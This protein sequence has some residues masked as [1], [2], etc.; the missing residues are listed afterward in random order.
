MSKIWEFFGT[1]EALVYV[2]DMDS[3]ELVYMNQKALQMYGFHS[4]DEIIGKKCYEVL[5]NCSAPCPMCNSRDLRQGYFKE[6]MY[7]NPVLERQVMLKATIVEVDGRKYRME[8]AFDDIKQNSIMSLEA[9][10]NKGVRVALQQETPSQTLEVLLEY[11]GKAL[12]GERTYIFERNEQGCDDNTYEWVA[13]GVT[14]EKDNLQNLPAEVCA[15]WYRNFRVGRHIVIEDLEDIRENDP[16]Q[17]E[18]LK[19]QN[20]HSLIVIPL[21]D[22]RQIIGFY[23]IDNPSEN[24]LDYASDMLQIMAHFI[25]SSLKRRNLVQRLKEMSYRDQLT[26]IGNRY[27]MN[28][29]IDNLQNERSLGIVYC[30]ITGL[31]QTNDRKGHAAGDKLIV[32]ACECLKKSFGEYG[33]FR[34]GGDE[35]LAICAEVKETALWQGI[36]QLKKDLQARSVHMA[37]G[38]IWEKDSFNGVEKLI[39]AAEKRMYKDKA[40]YYRKYD[41]DR[42]HRPEMANADKKYG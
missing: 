30:D 22:E 14:P 20:I 11:V 31:K 27:A 40:A 34:I 23:G 1:M 5:P 33:L 21:Y 37:I 18:N 25:I 38:G 16:L 10:I 15:N 41:T 35:L 4:L 29:Y 17:Y 32:D 9:R 6:W 26:Q 2:S 3:H 36:E 24:S 28:E 12:G 42:R 19:R 7:Y 13:K 8:L 39:T